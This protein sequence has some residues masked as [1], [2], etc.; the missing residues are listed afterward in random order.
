MQNKIINFLSHPIT[1]AVIRIIIGGLF[2]ISS[3]TKI[4]N[5]QKFAD[6]MSA[7][8]LVPEVIIPPFSILIPW[9]QFICGIFLILDIFV[10]SSALILCGLLAVYTLAISIDF[11][12][13]IQIDC[14]C[15]DLLGLDDK[16][17]LRA[18]IRDI[19]FL[20]MTAVVVLFDKNTV[21]FYGLIK[22][23]FK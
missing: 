17:G 4:T 7:Y 14:G 6:S 8:Q 15:F 21:N 18:I 9:L 1:L 12:R 10:Q 2:V 5:P 20:A 23:I 13:G 3:V 16:I 11:I 19:C 22:K